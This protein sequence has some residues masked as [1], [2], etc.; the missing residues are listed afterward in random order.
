MNAKKW[1]ITALVVVL[2]AAAAAVAYMYFDSQNDNGA[3]GG[4]G[5]TQ[6]SN[7]GNEVTQQ[8]TLYYVALNDNGIAGDKIGCDDSVVAITTAEV[9][10]S[11]VVK[12]SLERIL[13]DNSQFYG[14]SGL[15]NALYQ[16][17]IN[18]DGLVIDGDEATVRLSGSL[19]LSGACD[20]PR[21]KA[22]LEKTVA[23]ATKASQVAILLNNKP[24]DEA[25][26]A[27]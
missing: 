22:Q 23:E 8:L 17:D 4:S 6:N 14:E 1:L 5:N 10:T 9:T 2:V 7:Q 16:S 12:A 13:N 24:L 27:E 11:D 19:K 3:N 25:L 15:Y 26:S 21:V 20:S 18:Y